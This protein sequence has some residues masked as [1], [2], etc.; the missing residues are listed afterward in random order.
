MDLL[1]QLAHTAIIEHSAGGQCQLNKFH[2][3][4]MMSV[5]QF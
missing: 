5:D 2:I 3:V 1:A 4:L